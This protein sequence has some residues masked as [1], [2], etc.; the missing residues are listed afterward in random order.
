MLTRRKLVGSVGAL[1]AV[2]FLGG[3][4]WILLWDHSN[5]QAPDWVRYELRVPLPPRLM[6]F[7]GVTSLIVVGVLVGIT[8]VRR[9][10]PRP[11]RA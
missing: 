4:A 2:L 10:F 8:F 7:S 5:R 3:I 11:P 6:L 9:M 1:G